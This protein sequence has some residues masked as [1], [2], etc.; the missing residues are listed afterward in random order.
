MLYSVH[1]ACRLPALDDGWES[2]AWQQ[3][4]TLEIDHFRPEG[5]DHR[6][7]T[8]VRLLY[9]HTGI[10]GL[11]RVDDQYVRCVHTAYM[12]QVYKDSCVECFLQPRP[13][14]GYFN[15]EFNCGGTLRCSYITDP[16]RVA[17]GFRHWIPLPEEEGHQVCL[18]HSLP[19]I[20]EP[21]IPTPTQ[22]ALALFIPFGLLEKYVGV[23]GGMEGQHWR[24]N[25]YKCGDETSHPHWASWSPLEQRNFHWPECFGTIRFAGCQGESPAIFKQA[26]E[27]GA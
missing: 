3:A 15:F 17:D 23:L 2:P 24:A 9:D 25:F 7:R 19:R 13:D 27:D 20:I 1:K 26:P 21:E 16:T 10:C 5:S 4:E 8:S 14:K 18:Y 11:F 22:W 6:P 12:G